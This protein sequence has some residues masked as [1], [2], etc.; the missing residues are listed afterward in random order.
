LQLRHRLPKSVHTAELADNLHDVPVPR[1]GRHFQNLGNRE[2]RDAV[3]GILLQQF[4]QDTSRLGTEL[5]EEVPLLRAEPVGT[6]PSRPKGRVEGDVAQQVEGVCLGLVRS[7]RQF[8]EVDATLFQGINDFTAS[9]GIRPAA[10]Q[11][12]RMALP[13]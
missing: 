13:P 10:A 6:L 5:V 9:G 7:R 4:F 12:G 1:D 11:N 3:L 8:V 2:L